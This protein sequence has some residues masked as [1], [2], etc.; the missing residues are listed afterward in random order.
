MRQIQAGY[1]RGYNRYLASVG[2]ARGVPDPTCRGQAWVKPITLQD[3]YLRFY[4]LMLLNGD[5]AFI[6]GIGSAAPPKAARPAQ[7]KRPWPSP[8]RG[9]PRPSWPRAGTRCSTPSGSNAVAIGSAGTRDH[10]A[11]CWAT[12]TSRGSAPERFYQAQLTIPGQ[13]NVTGASLYGVP[14]ILIGHTASVAWSHT[15]S[16]A[17]RFTPYQLTLVKGHPT[18]YL[19]NGR[20]VAM[21]PTT[22]TVMTRQAGGKLAPV[23]RTLW[24]S[25][26]GPIADNLLGVP[27]PWTATTA[28]TMRDA[29]AGN[30]ARAMNTWFGFD[31]AQTTGQVLTILKKYQGIPWVN[32][33]VSDRQGQALYADIGTIP[34]VP[35]AL[36]RACD[37]ALGQADLGP[38]PAAG[39]GRLAHRLRLGHRPARGRA[40]PVRARPGAVAAAPRLRHQLQRQLLAVQPAPPSRRIPAHHGPG[41]TR[42]GRCAPGSA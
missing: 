42:R 26:Y 38:A 12:R 4:Q 23:T 33:V 9:G 6:D 1:V 35:D 34:G 3:S 20:P 10:P 37:T 2:G 16:T 7:P 32:T 27:L 36:A 41:R 17:R 8:T 40:G 21:T 5:D 24:S 14:L 28:F 29:N 13:I 18:E 15:V 31:R 19:E 22:V 25:R 39:A 30:L 11:C